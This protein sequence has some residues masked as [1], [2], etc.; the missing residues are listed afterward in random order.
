MD[1]SQPLNKMLI[2]AQTRLNRCIKNEGS[3]GTSAQS[4]MQGLRV[5]PGK[6]IRV[7]GS[8]DAGAFFLAV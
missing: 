6:G 7:Q 1:L 3:T 8:T 4:E 2:A 5:W